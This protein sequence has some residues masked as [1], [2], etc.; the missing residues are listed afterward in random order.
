MPSASLL[1]PLLPPALT[2]RRGLLG[3][4]NACRVF[5]GASDRLDGVFIDV[6]DAWATLIEYEGVVPRGFDAGREAAEVLEALQP[7]GVRGVYHK[8]FARDR[9]KM[10]GEL[11]AVTTD[12]TPIAGEAAPEAVVIREHGWRLEVRLWDG[13]STGIFLDQR[14][15]R[16]WL[17]EACKARTVRAGPPRVLNTFAYTGAFSVAA[18]L[19]GA[20]TT[21]VDVSPRYLEWAKRN[22]AHNGLEAGVADGTHRFAKM[23]TFEFIAYATRKGL[24]YDLII[25]D[26]PSFSAGSKKKGIPAWSSVADYA[27]LVGE[28]AG[29]LTR[30]GAIFASTN[31]RELCRS[32]RL[33][34]EVEKGLGRPVSRWLEL[35][36]PPV[37]FE[38]DEDRFASVGFV[39]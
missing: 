6:Y 14:E 4:G 7:L 1:T 36:P 15:N 23:D 37:D 20:M 24:R 28:A 30:G 10:G 18:A 12:P 21:T 22:F 8:P 3:G 26:P 33:E 39:V 2:R 27:R 13:L 19:G 5:S 9:S 11:P 34:R 32:G 38:R 25:L 35:P 29:L 31:T 17:H 16:R